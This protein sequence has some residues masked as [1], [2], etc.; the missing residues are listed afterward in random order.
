[1]HAAVVRT[2]HASIW[3]CRCKRIPMTARKAL[4]SYEPI[5]FFL[6]EAENH[7]QAA[8]QRYWRNQS[9][10]HT[11]GQRPAD[12]GC[13]SNRSR[14]ASSRLYAQAGSNEFVPVSAQRRQNNS[15]RRMMATQKLDRIVRDKSCTKLVHKTEMHLGQRSTSDAISPDYKG[16]MIKTN[17]S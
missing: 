8:A 7:E 13:T 9:S 11:R 6:A 3:V 10:A 14:E 17:D 1:M 15:Q 16:L 4:K 5:V 12:L 2:R